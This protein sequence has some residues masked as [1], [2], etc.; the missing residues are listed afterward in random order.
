MHKSVIKDVICW[1]LPVKFKMEVELVV[2]T[3]LIRKNTKEKN[4]NKQLYNCNLRSNT[5][6]ANDGKGTKFQQPA[7]VCKP[8][9]DEHCHSALF[10]TSRI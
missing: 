2:P 3:A 4:G 1:R 10:P 6:V 8:Q 7:V 5:L 9:V